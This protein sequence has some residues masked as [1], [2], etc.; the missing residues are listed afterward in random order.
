[1]L[2]KKCGQFKSK[3]DQGQDDRFIR[4]TFL[5]MFVAVILLTLFNCN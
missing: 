1:M 4:T 3:K 2:R 5:F